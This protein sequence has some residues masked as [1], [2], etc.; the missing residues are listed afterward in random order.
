MDLEKN[1]TQLREKLTLK[2]LSKF[3]N[4]LSEQQLMTVMIHRLTYDYVTVFQE[5]THLYLRDELILI[6]KINLLASAILASQETMDQYDPIWNEFRYCAN[7]LEI[8]FKKH[9]P[10]GKEMHIELSGYHKCLHLCEKMEC[11]LFG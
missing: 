7:L 3:P 5:R 9:C 10:V 2:L 1:I 11:H 6:E 4:Q 8:N